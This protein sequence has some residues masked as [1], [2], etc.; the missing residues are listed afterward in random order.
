ME[1]TQKEWQAKSYEVT[2]VETQK[3]ITKIYQYLHALVKQRDE[4]MRNIYKIR[5]EK[6]RQPVR[7]VFVARDEVDE[8]LAAADAKTKALERENRALVKEV[9]DLKAKQAELEVQRHNLECER[10]P[11][12]KFV[13]DMRA[14][15]DDL[16]Q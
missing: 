6:N 1:N 4:L 5:S 8:T 2:G 7:K 3:Q 14:A 13:R 16:S 15:I 10:D 9:S 11:W 12:K